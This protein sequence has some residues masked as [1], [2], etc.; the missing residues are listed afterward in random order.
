MLTQITI[1]LCYCIHMFHPL[2]MNPEEYVVIYFQEM[3]TRNDE[4]FFGK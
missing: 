3:H 4:I 1:I 2:E